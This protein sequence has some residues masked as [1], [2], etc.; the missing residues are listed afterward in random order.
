MFNRRVVVLAVILLLTVALPSAYAKEKQSIS[1]DQK[2]KHSGA[3]ENIDQMTNNNMAFLAIQ[4][5]VQN[6][7]QQ[8]QTASNIA[9]ADSDAKANAVRNVRS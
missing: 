4:T 2:I 7:S 5:K 9:K 3:Q 6:I 8:T 1:Q